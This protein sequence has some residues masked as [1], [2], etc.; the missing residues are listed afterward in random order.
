MWNLERHFRRV[1]PEEVGGLEL[2]ESKVGKCVICGKATTQD[3]PYVCEEHKVRNVPKF[4][5]G[6]ILL[7][8]RER[9]DDIIRKSAFDCIDYFLQT[10]LLNL[11]SNVGTDLTGIGY[12][13]LAAF[14][15]RSFFLSYTLLRLCQAFPSIGERAY[16]LAIADSG[17]GQIR[18]RYD[19]EF[20]EALSAEFDYFYA[21]YFGV[22]GLFEIA[23]D[24]LE[25]PT[26][27]VILPSTSQEAILKML[28]LRVKDSEFVYRCSSYPIIHETSTECVYNGRGA[29]FCYSK[30][31]IAENFNTFKRIWLK[32]F[33]SELP[34]NASEY[35]DF[36]DYFK[37]VASPFG[38][39]KKT[40][41]KA[42]YLED[43][44]GLKD[45]VLFSLLNTILADV[46]LK[47]DLVSTRSLGRRDPNFKVLENLHRV[48]W[49]FRF[50][51]SKGMA[52]YLPV[53]AWLKNLLSPLLVRFGRTLNI[54]GKFYE[55]WIEGVI[56]NL[57]EG[58]LGF[59]FT[60]EFGWVPVQRRRERQQTHSSWKILEKNLQITVED[61]STGT[62]RQGEVDLIIY[63]NY[64]I[65]LLELKSL[66]LGG[67]RA[68][69]HLNNKAPKQCSRYARWVRNEENLKSLMAKHNIPEHKLKSVRI[70]CCT[71]GVYDKTS[72]TDPDTSERFAVIPLFLLF[73]LFAGVFNLAVRDVFPPFISQIRNGLHMAQS[74]LYKS[75]LLD[76]REKLSELANY[77]VQDWYA[78]MT[79]DRRLDF[80]R[81]KRI[82]P[83][84]FGLARFFVCREVYIGDTSNWILDEPLLLDVVGGYRYYVATQIGDA[85]TTLLCPHCRSVVKYYLASDEDDDNRVR[86]LLK[87]SKC[88]FC[89]ESAQA[90]SEYMEIVQHMSTCILDIKT[91][92][93]SQTLGNDVTRE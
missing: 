22:N 80:G 89:H 70:L 17:G 86:T 44:T 73:N 25:E 63:A 60:R 10:F 20:I 16:E 46:C 58:R 68:M 84:A 69:K 38:F 51:S 39:T 57:A 11:Y 27:I 36:V 81:F 42:C 78:L 74:S 43:Y 23:V 92:L 88:P 45:D 3:M 12:R 2:I 26:M 62:T 30:Q 77:I 21:S 93:D 59:Q 53:I 49:G 61:E 64:S 9:V 40:K 65:Y 85:G 37:W 18:T 56:Q 29:F 5:V 32:I 28:M 75:Y 54:A 6:K 1:H 87:D 14:S 33:G 15:D 72:V 66:N 47:T 67:K 31:Q 8:L 83:Q 55:R 4:L 24:R 48:S 41:N 34:V 52:Y 76:T 90:A 82:A 91:R 19:T 71:N 7:P 79:F 50:S 13:K 35:E